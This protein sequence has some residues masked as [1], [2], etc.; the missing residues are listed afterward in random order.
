MTTRRFVIG[1]MGRGENA[2]AKDVRAA[3]ELGERI[4]R[5]GWVLLTGGRN[6]GVMAAANRGAKRVAGSLTVGVLPS[7]G[8]PY[9]D[10][11][12][13][14]DVAIF[15]GMGDARDA[16][17]V[18]SSDVVVVCGAAGAG[19]AAEAALAVKSK[20]RLVL[21]DPTPEAAAFLTSL[22]PRVSIASAAAEVIALILARDWGS[23]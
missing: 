5:E 9:A 23:E 16:V 7:S 10:V 21:L 14:V 17:N 3:E 2:L 22:D 8:G 18:L 11:S 19:T 6:A 1:V 12:P 4:A 13:D 20:R 15:T